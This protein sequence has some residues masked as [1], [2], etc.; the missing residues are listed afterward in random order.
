MIPGHPQIL[1]C[2]FC[3]KEKEIMSILSGNTCRTKLWSD[4]KLIAPMLPRASFVQKC[5]HCG[6][7]FILTRQERRFAKEGCSFEKGLLSYPE[8]KEAF[9]QLSQEGYQD[10]HEEENVRTMLHHAYN[11]YYHRGE[12]HPEI[13]AEDWEL[14]VNNAKW[15]I[16]NV[17]TGDAIK[18]EFYREI[19]EFD[20]ALSLLDARKPTGNTFLEEIVKTVRTKAEN[21]DNQV[22]RIR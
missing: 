7:Y 12:E 4:N 6:K 22:F 13:A 11:D 18:A 14:F 16:D 5:P 8:M 19:G 15:I 21:K 1:T 9:A 2:P 3:G 20:K 17:I 10:H